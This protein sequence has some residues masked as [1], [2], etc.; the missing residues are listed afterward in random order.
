MNDIVSE[1]FQH[2]RAIARDINHKLDGT[3]SADQRLRNEIAGMFAVTVAASYEGIVRET[4]VGYAGKFHP[5]YRQHVEKDFENLNARIKIEDLKSYSRRFGLPVWTG[6]KVK[7]NSTTFHKILDDRRKVVERRFRADL[8]VSY[9]SIFTWRNSYAHERTTPAT[10]N[11]VY[12][13]H[14]VGQYVIKSFVQ[15]FEEG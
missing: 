4:L 3:S 13:A 1:N 7:K 12:Q 10:F 2:I 9:T 6:H 14:R 15:A 11:D 8:I 5:K